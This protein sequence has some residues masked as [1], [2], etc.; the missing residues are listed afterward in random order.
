VGLEWG[1]LSL[2]S[3]TDELLGR[4]SSGS[5]LET[6]DY[7]RRDPSPCPRGTICQQNLALTGPANGGR[8]VGVVRSWNHATEFFFL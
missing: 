2:V 4:K 6:R 1:P 3:A 8:S 5:S 7:G